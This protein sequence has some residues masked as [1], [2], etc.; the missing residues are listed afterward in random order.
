VSFSSYQLGRQ[1]EDW[2][3]QYLEQSGWILLTR[4]FRGRR[5]EIDVVARHGPVL[6]FVEIKSSLRKPPFEALQSRQIGRVR[7]AAEEYLQKE[8]LSLESEMR[9]DVIRVWGQP[10]QLDHL[11]DAF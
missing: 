10:P 4:N 9:F 7:G 3:I 6:V 2:V 1:S 8:R 11:Q 5:G